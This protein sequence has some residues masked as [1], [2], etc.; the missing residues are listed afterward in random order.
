MDNFLLNHMITL[1]A[2]KPAGGGQG[3]QQWI[4]K[5]KQDTILYMK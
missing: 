5:K 1:K 4:V 3:S 2:D